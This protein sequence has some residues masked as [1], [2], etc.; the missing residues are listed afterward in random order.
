MA[1]I[2][3]N[4]GGSPAVIDV[5]DFAMES[6]MQ[7]ILGVQRKM[8]AEIAG[9]SSGGSGSGGGGG[10]NDLERAL[11]DNTREIKKQ[12]IV[13][14]AGSRIQNGVIGASAA[15]RTPDA[16]EVVEKNLSR[17]GLGA[18]AANFGAMVGVMEEYSDA[19]G[20]AMQVGIGFT[21][22]FTEL[23][24]NVSAIGLSMGQFGKISIEN[25]KAI[26]GFGTS[27]DDGA[28]RLVA[29][30]SEFRNASRSVGY[31]GMQSFEMTQLM[32]DELEIRR[33]TMGQDSLRRM[34]EAELAAATADNLKVQTAMAAITGQDVRDRLKAQNEARKNVVA[35][36]FLAG[37]SDETREKFRQLASSLSSIPGGDQ[38]SKALLTGVATGLDPRQFAPQMFAMLEGG[39]QSMIDFINGNLAGGMDSTSFATGVQELANNLTSSIPA[40]QLRIMSATGNESAT[41][42]LTISQQ[43]VRTAD[44]V[45]EFNNN[46]AILNDA[47]ANNFSAAG[48]NADLEETSRLIANAAVKAVMASAGIQDLGEMGGAMRELAGSFNQGLGSPRFLEMMEGV[49]GIMGT[50]SGLLPLLEGFRGNQNAAE[51]TLTG[52]GLFLQLTGNDKAAMMA[53]TAAM[54]IDNVAN[55]VTKITGA[56]GELLSPL[57]TALDNLR[58]TID[59]WDP[60]PSIF[61]NSTSS[62]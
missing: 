46:L 50:M 56:Q 54:G 61:P 25:S 48:I 13:S 15:Q 11:N 21:T 32:A 37:Q 47:V 42:M 51:N 52:T 58:N 10:S 12:G 31:F 17:I 9:V 53:F 5:P 18:L 33:A 29:L 34:G 60:F 62:N 38:I 20:K 26:R 3:L 2:R 41:A 44:L 23:R 6:T 8:L 16:S 49:G 59:N 39:G 19:I 57:T 4:I 22:D 55:I 24:T 36:S 7:D 40:E 35:Q 1:E 43:T 27:T 30:T 28:Q 14:R 45:T